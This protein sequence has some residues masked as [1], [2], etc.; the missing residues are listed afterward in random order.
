M[1]HYPIKLGQKSHMSSVPSPMELGDVHYP[2]IFLHWKKDYKLPD[3]GEMVVKFKKVRETHTTTDEEKTHE[4]T[5]EVHEIVSVKAS[6]KDDED[7][8]SEEAIDKLAEDYD[9]EGED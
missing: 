7:E 9:K 5:L 2:T 1:P 3:S 8:S 6:K 4:V